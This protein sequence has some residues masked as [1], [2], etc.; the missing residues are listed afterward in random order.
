[1]PANS[2]LSVPSVPDTPRPAPHPNNKR[3]ITLIK[4]H[5]HA[6][7]AHRV[8]DVIDIDCNLADWLV[9]EGAATV[10]LPDALDLKNTNRKEQ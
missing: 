6:N 7:I 10:T 4:Q 1:M 2:S 8:G 9:A 5:I 3:R